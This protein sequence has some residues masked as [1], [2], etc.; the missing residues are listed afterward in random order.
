MEVMGAKC[1]P[2]YYALHAREYPPRKKRRSTHRDGSW[3]L[4]PAFTN[5]LSV[6]MMINMTLDNQPKTKAFFGM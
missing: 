4:V 1:H 5:S 6:S 3:E 2:Y